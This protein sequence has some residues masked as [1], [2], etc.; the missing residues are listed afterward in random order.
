MRRVA[1]AFRL[2]GVTAGCRLTGKSM[3]IF[4][5]RDYPQYCTHLSKMR[6]LFAHYQA[7]E[8]GLIPPGRD[9]FTVRGFSYPAGRMVDFAVDFKYSRDGKV[10]WRERLI[11]PVTGL[12]SRMR[13]AFHFLHIEASPY[14]D[15]PIYISEQVTPLHRFLASQFHNLTASEFLGDQVPLGAADEKGIRN[16]DLTRLTFPD[17]SFDCV[18]SLD[19]LEHFPAFL[20]AFEEC[21]RVLK[22][23]GRMLWSVPFSRTRENVTRARLAD[24]GTV[25]H[26]LEPIYHGDPLSKQGCLCFTHF[27][28]EMLEQVREVGFSDAY[29]LLFWSLEYGYLGGEQILFMAHRR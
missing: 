17:E 6:G 26:L 14:P 16:E 3:R 2:T 19:C 8:Q 10:N 27:G 24:D 13:A 9:Q 1:A 23:G 21:R 15:D 29:A 12:N 25:E 20:Q 18:V 5:V 7:T 11:C 4:R 28:W 22:P